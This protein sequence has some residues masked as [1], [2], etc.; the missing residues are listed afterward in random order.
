[1]QQATGAPATPGIK[2]HLAGAGEAA[3]LQ[4]K[5]SKGGHQE[6][7]L[8]APA[9]LPEVA[10][11]PGQCSKKQRR[12]AKTAALPASPQKGSPANGTALPAANGVA[13]AGAADT[14]PGDVTP[15]FVRARRAAAT[16][17]QRKK[18]NF[19]LSR[20]SHHL[21]GRQMQPLE[22]PVTSPDAQPKVGHA[23]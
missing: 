12:Q 7:M 9:A 21:I 19:V 23:R 2:A 17:P 6:R 3:P 10:A 16:A 22:V 5:Q 15:P 13:L 20:N 4:V 1:M 18:V 14:A 11:V 8:N